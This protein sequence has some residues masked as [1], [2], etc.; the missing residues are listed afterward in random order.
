MADNHPFGGASFSMSALA[1]VCAP[2]GA[3]AILAAVIGL[4]QTSSPTGVN[5]CRRHTHV[6]AAIC[7]LKWRSAAAF[8][9]MRARAVHFPISATNG[10]IF[11]AGAVM[12]HSLLAMNTLFDTACLPPFQGMS[13]A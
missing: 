9:Q 4:P 8:A 5:K 3:V 2:L 12:K 13:K 1:P 11:L 10:L 7:A 6:H